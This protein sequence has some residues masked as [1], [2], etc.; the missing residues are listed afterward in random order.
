MKKENSI[1]TLVLAIGLLLICLLSY[2]VS[3]GQFGFFLD[4]WYIIWTYKTF[5]AEKFVDFF[6]GDRPLF[7]IVYQIIIPIIKDSPLSWQ[8]F[9]IFTKW[10]AAISLWALLK[11]LLPKRDSFTYAVTA[12]F[13]VYPGFKFHYFAVMYGQNYLLLSLYF[14]SYIFMMKGLNKNKHNKL[15]TVLGL[16]CQF[17][18]IAPM[19]LYYGLEFVRPL[20]LFFTFRKDDSNLKTVLAKTIKA[21][22]P[23]S[24]VLIGFT[25]FRV[26]FRHLYSYEV[27]T[28]QNLFNDP[29]NA[30]ISLVKRVFIGL[31]DS[32]VLVWLKLIDVFRLTQH[33]QQKTTVF[34]LIVAGF[35]IIYFSFRITNRKDVVE[36]NKTFYYLMIGTGFFAT[37]TAMIPVII[38]GFDIGLSFPVNRH[39]L[40]LSIGA[41]LSTIGIIELLFKNSSLK[42]AIIALLIALSIGANYV[43][44]LEFKK[45]WDDQTSFFAQLTWRVPQMEPNT[46]LLSTTLPFDRYFSGPS[47]TAPLNMI[48][49]PE[50]RDNPIP[51]QMILSASPQMDSMP[52]LIPDQDI[53]RTSRVFRFVGN[54]SDSLAV[55]QPVQGCLKILSPETDPGAF[56]SDRYYYLWKDIIPLSN[57]SRIKTETTRVELPARYFG[58]VSRDNWCYYYES[59]ALA[60]QELNWNRVVNFYKEAEAN[61]YKPEDNSE[62]LPLIKAL[63]NKGDYKA[64]L[65][66]S[67]ELRIDNSFTKCGLCS[68]WK[69]ESLDIPAEETESVNRLLSLWGCD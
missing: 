23:Y 40:P 68:L 10:L 24:L 8:I 5:G 36:S 57:F 49:V 62:W 69:N 58:N 51:Y 64:A 37:L 9:A 44:G 2:G 26:L 13:A 22:L 67:G 47:L 42:K 52:A 1:Q 54:T 65:M 12:L 41:S 25:L 46:V 6:R 4:D 66:I 56:E 20:V 7:P 43:N 45:A 48:Y 35:L 55:Y 60:E 18:G 14:L 17:I 31:I 30:L 53:D 19:E 32:L 63:I 34:L 59:A 15:F 33:Y 38:G 39:L 61:G 29:I 16:I 50:L 27:S 11:L 3:I 28:L 21:W